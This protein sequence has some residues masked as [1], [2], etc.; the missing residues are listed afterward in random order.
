MSDEEEEEKKEKAKINHWPL[1]CLA[2]T[3]SVVPSFLPTDRTT[4][5]DDAREE[6]TNDQRYLANHGGNPCGAH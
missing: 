2:A 1:L 5:Q 3:A 6:Q 4:T